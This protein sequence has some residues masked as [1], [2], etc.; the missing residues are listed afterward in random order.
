M[1]RT[2]HD[3]MERDFAVEAGSDYQPETKGRYG[4]DTVGL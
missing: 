4:R 2:S 3:E 1:P